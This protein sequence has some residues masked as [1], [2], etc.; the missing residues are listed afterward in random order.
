MLSFLITHHTL[1]MQMPCHGSS[2]R[3][4]QRKKWLQEDFTPPTSLRIYLSS[5][6]APLIM[7]PQLGN[8]GHSITMFLC[9]Q[10]VPGSPHHNGSYCI[11]KQLKFFFFFPFTANKAPVLMAG[12]LQKEKITAT[13]SSL[14]PN[15]QNI[16]AAAAGGPSTDLAQGQ[17]RKR[18]GESKTPSTETDQP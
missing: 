17:K 1:F 14:Q 11:S 18:D 15:W 9:Y 10:W 3:W 4:T 8:V 2:P 7:I 13:T 16:M 12:S 5:L 6:V